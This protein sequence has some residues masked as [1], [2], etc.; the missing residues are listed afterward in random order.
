MSDYTDNMTVE[1]AA[2]A[3]KSRKV[4]APKKPKKAPGLVETVIKGV[5]AY[6]KKIEKSMEER[7]GSKS[8]RK[9]HY[10]KRKKK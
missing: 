2:K 4:K 10:P 9:K 8:M 5:K 7:T 3:I 6:G 1:E